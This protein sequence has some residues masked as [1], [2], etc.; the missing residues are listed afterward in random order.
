M[1]CDEKMKTSKYTYMIKITIKMLLSGARV[2][3]E[4]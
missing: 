1:F 2:E 3:I 4:S